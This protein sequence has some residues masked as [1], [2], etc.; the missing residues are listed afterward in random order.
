MLLMT[1]VLKTARQAPESDQR[2]AECTV[3]KYREFRWKLPHL[4]P[5][6]FRCQAL[7]LKTIHLKYRLAGEKSQTPS[8]HGNVRGTACNP[9]P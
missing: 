2:T 9:Y 8:S 4:T 7:S 5:H 1:A 3:R 6:C